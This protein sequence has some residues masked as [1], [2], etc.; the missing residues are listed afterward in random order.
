MKFLFKK[1]EFENN[2]NPTL[3]FLIEK[4]GEI[5]EGR[6]GTLGLVFFL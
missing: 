1:I 3:A 6:R 4:K 5:G 2:L